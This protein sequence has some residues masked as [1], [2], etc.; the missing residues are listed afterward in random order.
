MKTW[1][2]VADSS[3]GRI[4]SAET[5]T[6]ALNEIETLVHPE[7]RLHEQE[8]DSDLPGKGR[9]AA[10][11]GGHAYQD[12]TEPKEQEVIDF[13]KRIAKHLDDARKAKKY[14]RLLIV[15]APAFLGELRN[16]FPDAVSKSICFDLDKNLTMHS[17]DDI[18]KHLPERLPAKT[19]L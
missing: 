16:Q 18:R 10:G 9:G 7:G 1:I 13:A 2:L 11:A 3:R 6:S 15:S 4:F 17:T 8:M 5:S 12:E 19:A 14:E